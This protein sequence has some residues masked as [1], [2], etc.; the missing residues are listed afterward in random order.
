MKMYC[1]SDRFSFLAVAQAS[2]VAE[3]REAMLLEMGESGDG[4]CPERDAARRQIV[5]TN[6]EIWQ[7]TNAEFALT[8]S[9]ELSE[10]GDY[11]QRLNARIGELEA[12]LA[13]ARRAA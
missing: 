12:E 10:M 1:W 7:G 6:P 4:S 8:D 5:T 13:E 9:A 11:V 2:S 3:A